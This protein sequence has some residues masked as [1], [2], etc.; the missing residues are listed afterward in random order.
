VQKYNTKDI[1]ISRRCQVHL[2]I[3]IEMMLVGLGWQ[4][5]IKSYYLWVGK[6]WYG[7]HWWKGT[8]AY[9]S[10]TLGFIRLSRIDAS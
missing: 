6:K 8:K 1:K 2:Y 9:D 5:D 7:F 3:N 4:N 10:M